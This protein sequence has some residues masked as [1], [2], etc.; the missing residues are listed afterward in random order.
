M[1]QPFNPQR[2]SNSSQASQSDSEGKQSFQ[3]S[4][5]SISLPKGGGAI[6][7][8]G[9]KFAANPVTGTGSMTVPVA[10]SPGRSGFGP[11]LSLSYDS[12]AGNGPFGF[13]WSLSLPSITRKTD[14]GLPKYQDA[15]E[16]DVFILSGAE[17]LV[18]ILVEENGHWAR[19]ILLPRNI[20]G[21]N[22]RV[23]RYRPRIEGL[24]ARIEHWTNLTDP[25]DTFWRSI[26]KDNIT[27]YYG[28]SAESR[29]ADPGD[30]TWIFSWLIC[31]SYDDKGNAI[32]YEYREEDSDEVDLSQAHEKNRTTEGRRA[33][34]YLKRV[35][36]GNRTPNRDADTWQ[37]TD[38]FQLPDDTW[39]FE[40][41]FDYE[42]GHYEA[43][44]LDPAR[45]EAE[46][47]R[48]VSAS[49]S[50]GVAWP[51]RADP[52]SVYRAGFEVRT[53]RLCQRVLMFHHFADELGTPDYLVRSTEFAYNPSPIASFITQVTQSG[54]VRQSNG[55]YL[56]ESLP[57]LSF[58]Y[59]KAVINDEIETLDAE[60]L[61]NLPVGADGLHYQW[62]DLDG[63]GLQGVLSEQQEGWYYKRNLSPIS[64]VKEN[65]KEKVV[66]RLEP[67]TE[68]T[69]QPSIAEGAGGRHQ[70]LDLAGD[71]NL[72]LVQFE[73][74]VSGYFERIEDERWESFIPFESVPNLSWND[75]NLRFVDL[76]GDG[77][78]DILITEDD[79]LTWYPSLAEE[80]FGT[81]FRV[82]K[83]RDDEVG[84]AVVFAD[85]T[86]AIFVADLSG[87]GLGD[88]VRIRNG[89][90]CYWP[91]LGYGRFGAKVTMDNA[92]WFDTPDQF[93]QKR[94]RLADIDGSGTTDIIYLERK[95][96]AIYRN[97]CGNGWSS[98]EYLT[99]FPPV[100]D[101][102]TVTAVDL[103]G[104]GTACLVWSSPLPGNAR[105][106]MRYI[107][108][109]G[110]QKPHLLIK[111][112]NNLGAET[113]FEYAPST[114]FYLADKLAGKPWITRLPFP[115]QVVEQVETHD[116]ISRNRFV[117]RYAYHHGYFD[118][119]ERE[120]R[121]FGMVEK[122][123]TDEIG[124]LK[125]G[126][127]LPDAS[128]ID[129]SSY[130]PPAYTKTWFHTG[131]YIEGERISRHFEDE[132]Y[133]EGDESEG[134]SGLT[135]LQ[136]E[137]MLLPDTKLPTT[138]KRRDG[139]SVPWELAAGEIREA[140]R[141]LKGA[142]LRREIFA[143]DG[144]E[145]EDRPY[146]ATE[147]NYTIEL[148]QPR[149]SQRHAI[150]FTHARE[151]IDFHYERKLFKVVG[152]TVVDPTTA[153]P[154]AKD[155][156]DP[157]VTHAM[158]LEVD[159]YG[160]VLKSVA[161]GYGRRYDDSSQLLTPQDRDK[162]KRIHVTY[163]E[164]RFTNPVEEPDDYRT[165]LPAAART[166]ELIQL[167]RLSPGS[168]QPEITKLFRF[169]EMLSKIQASSD[170]LHDLP[171]EDIDAAGATGNHRRLIEHA[172][173]LYR[174][175]DL[176]VAQNDPLVLLPL[177]TV[178]SLALPG[179]SY[180]L[181]FTPGLL[182]QVF[183]RN[184]QALL[185]NP[186]DV[187]LVDVL[188][189]QGAHRGGY[190]DLDSN[191]QWW[192]PSGRVFCS[193]TPN[194]LPA[195]ELAF[196][197]AHFFL[198]HRYRDPFHT[199]AVSTENFVTYD[200]HDLLML[201]TRD[202]LGNRITVGERLPNGNIDATK[203]GNDYRV[204]QPCLV[205]D[206]NRNRT[207]AAFDALGMVVGTAMMGKPGEN[208]G[209]NLTNFKTGLTQKKINDFH[210][211]AD[212]HG[213]AETHLKG[214]ISR[215][216][217]DLHRFHLSQQAHPTDST[218]WEAPYAA[219]LSRE[220]HASDP[221]PPGGLKIQL[222][223]SYSDGF[224]RETQKKIQAE[225]GPLVEGGSIVDPRWV[226]SGWTVFNNK[227]KPVRQY[228]PFFDDTHHFKF[229]LAV[230]V[231]PILFYDP[232]ERV[233]AMLHPNHAWEKVVFDP[234][235]QTS[236]DVNDTVL[237][238]DGTTD[239]R[240]DEDVT[241][242][243]SR[244]PDGAYLPTWYEERIALAANNPERFAAEK[245]AV[246]RQTPTVAHFDSLGR[247]FLT[248]AHNRFE[249]NGAML[250]EKYA[251]R[252]EL[253][254]EGNQRQ[255]VDANDRVVMR[256][257]Y[258]MLGNRIHQA[259]ME[260]GE[261]WMLNDVAG[262][263]LYAWDS[264]HHQFRTA[265]D[266]LR[267]PTDSF[268]REGT[269]PERL[270]GHTAYGESQP[271][272][273]VKNQRGRAV[274]LFDQ[275][276][277]VTSDEYD[278]KG[279]LLQSAR[280]VADDYKKIYDWNNDIV[281]PSWEIFSSSTAYDALNRPT[282]LT[283][284][285]TPS[286]QPSVIHPRYN[287]ANLLEKVDVNL[288]G[289]QATTPFVTNIDYNAKGQR[290][291]IDY[292][293]GA[294]T[295]YDYDLVTFGLLRLVTQRNAVD[296]PD[297]CPQPP[298]VG[299]PGCQVQNLH[300]TYDP[301]GNITHV[302]DDAQQTIY[303]KNK[304]VEP[305]ADY[306]YDAI[307][308]LIEATGREHLGQVGGAPIPHSYNDAPR[309]G[310]VNPGP[311]NRYNPCDGNVMSTYLERYV[312]D[313]V[314]NFL[315]MRDIGSDPAN[316]G[317]TRSYTYDEPSLIEPGKKSNRLSRTQV[318]SGITALPESYA[319]DV[320][321]N[322]TAMPHLPHMN[323]NFKDELQHVDLGGGGDAYYVYDAGGQR[324][325]KVVE[326]NGGALIEERIYLGGFEIFRR[327]NGAGTVM[328]E[329]ET[330]HVMDN[331]QRIALVET[332]TL[333]TAGT[334]SAPAQ[335][336]RYQFGNHLGSA[337]LELDDE[338]QIISYEEYYP[339][340]S[341]SYQAGRSAAEVS[342]KRYRYTGK[343]RDQE[344]GLNYHGVRYYAPWLGRW[345]SSDPGGIAD[346]PSVYVYV[347]DN[348]VRLSDPSGTQSLNEV[349]TNIESRLKSVENTLHNLEG[350]RSRLAQAAQEYSDTLPS[351]LNAARRGDIQATTKLGE[352]INRSQRLLASGQQELEAI[353]RT[354]H[355]YSNIGNLRGELE[356]AMD[357]SLNSTLT[358]D[359]WERMHIHGE[360]QRL[361]RALEEAEDLIR[362]G[363]DRLPEIQAHQRDA[364]R[365][366]RDFQP[367]G[368]A[369]DALR[370]LQSF[371]RLAG[372]VALW[373]HYGSE[374]IETSRD[375]KIQK[376]TSEHVGENVEELTGSKVVA[377]AATAYVNAWVS[378]VVGAHKVAKQAV[379]QPVRNA[380]NTFVKSPGKTI[381][382]HLILGPVGWIGTFT[383]LF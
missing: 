57:P 367:L 269:G 326:R 374:V 383:G 108:L 58:E 60:S 212:P 35:K 89:E 287:E 265:Y 330:V 198:P 342:L 178:Q 138:L 338:A 124:A 182:A 381:A 363:Q 331:K 17:D 98:A 164:N 293:N 24:F 325:R 149:A 135:D 95:Q 125:A 192:V 121:G 354:L 82:P 190:V 38:P 21:V 10:T 295:L 234:W 266:P 263:P 115:V 308:R 268:L 229:R 226:G 156:A 181:A 296:F 297:D 225:A 274:Q 359:E 61:Q 196:A 357:P 259:S 246:H 195:S 139:S 248:V 152:N 313:A 19:E 370:V 219:T 172:R 298:P 380:A 161:I 379:T 6:R 311:T 228:E 42:E 205:M 245:A 345:T 171:N 177:G 119:E 314:G 69:A 300:Y 12:G 223:F 347:R 137:A 309:V 126:G 306:T 348:P 170:G 200:T 227:G 96:V 73:R 49:A 197:R 155:V 67:L 291:R 56:K 65:G 282:E 102:S 334:D 305:S 141:A 99:S 193:L 94:I 202:A 64:T 238:A 250:E 120:F 11:Q 373:I 117:T 209:D 267:R 109:M 224:G 341:T 350:I 339:Y 59:S 25:Q 134:V 315:S 371:L 233:V 183:Q 128:N 362:A 92:P 86:Q 255:V 217:Y 77:H 294:S 328:L 176:G 44:P 215:F 104:N 63:E 90:I 103:L 169:D 355:E 144:T 85:G 340:G 302:R 173:T 271:N 376:F 310:I 151:S 74:P 289:A 29:I 231:S 321:G 101:L 364:A 34:R 283:T 244:L 301:A 166:Y 264:R 84:P 48:F 106:P 55:T 142:V 40:V 272:P 320:H 218:R 75:P 277:V 327:R 199:N 260:A 153:P 216:V 335:L 31:Q 50:A 252:V 1:N 76:T 332:R 100:D 286:M 93:D 278:F 361:D 116:L 258:D 279:N 20:S 352:I 111:T 187:L 179:E 148:L 53:Y 253:D 107:D 165:P 312:Y 51:V 365:L 337:S 369:G 114:K 349:V 16:S 147:Q 129:E 62:L 284:P 175:D 251:T 236:Y 174:P 329:R 324:V 235:Q 132:Y 222:S 189:G 140:C 71:G 186:A 143:Q 14:K 316:P 261:R 358:P 145:D 207:A 79:A 3:I 133:H 214:A 37:A 194:D 270:I 375:P 317:W 343:E 158:T 201:E 254:V 213:L 22:Y 130:V 249:R 206:P 237:N 26:S 88:I 290:T 262:K 204:L 41:V 257:D 336:I 81:A 13:G 110:G 78:A 70:F 66:A 378:S 210:D 292:G 318:G 203:T 18:P 32:V 372:D 366:A 39:M 333:D 113:V 344:T 4:A 304:R 188:G 211:A 87:D 159:G 54:Y 80:G 97:E 299:W 15:E 322:M 247:P 240:L 157:R 154:T 221:L 185:P 168:N 323:W 167:P 28:K 242:F 239:P 72:D 319:Y 353:E 382:K 47:H 127:T 2:A 160:N 273:E 281:Q 288:R 230:G 303:F 163:S 346:M 52:F 91:N 9:E 256:Y 105:R 7:G 276:G 36:Y 23:Q 150:F 191:G 162:Q 136:L 68:V 377:A 33:N 232:V 122:W 351:Y 8:M 180:K 184:G 43:L 83:P 280:T 307:Y 368:F 220:T 123:D 360:G 45:P 243:V 356:I 285:H 27:T 5:P 118:G 131:A 112:V 208:K 241:E 46:Q 275:A 146:S 30:P